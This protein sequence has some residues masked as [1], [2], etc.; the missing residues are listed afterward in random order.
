MS[1]WRKPSA[2]TMS[3]TPAAS[4]QL[5]MALE[6]ASAAEGQQALRQLPVRGLLQA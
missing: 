6:E 4:Q 5:Q 3:R 2:R 1:S